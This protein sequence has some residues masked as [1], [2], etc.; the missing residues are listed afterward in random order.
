MQI[1]YISDEQAMILAAVEQFCKDL[2]VKWADAK[3]HKNDTLAESLD[4]EFHKYVDLSL[5]I[6]GG[7][8]KIITDKKDLTAGRFYVPV[9]GWQALRYN[10]KGGLTGG[11][12]ISHYSLGDYFP[13]V[14]ANAEQIKDFN[15]HAEQ[16]EKSIAEMIDRSRK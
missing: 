5:K 15:A 2:L 14:E 3:F 11:D 4:A 16:V 9:G 12:G 10:G 1:K 8:E 7:M 6:K 13:L